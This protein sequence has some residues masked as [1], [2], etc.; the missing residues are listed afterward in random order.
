MKSPRRLTSGESPRRRLSGEAGKYYLPFGNNVIELRRS[1]NLQ[2]SINM[3]KCING[4]LKPFRYSL[5]V[6]TGFMKKSLIK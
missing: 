6:Y 1:G 5:P 3:S 2:V 4:R